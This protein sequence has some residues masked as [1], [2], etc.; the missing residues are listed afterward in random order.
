MDSTKNMEPNVHE[1]SKTSLVKSEHSH[2]K[3]LYTMDSIPQEPR[4]EGETWCTARGKKIVCIVSIA[5]GLIGAAII[6][7]VLC[8]NYASMPVTRSDCEK[9]CGTNGTCVLSAQW[10]DGVSDCPN[11]EDETSCVQTRACQMLCGSSGVC[12]LYS[13]WCD[14]IPQ[15]PNGTDEQT[16]VRLYGPNFQLQAYSPAK[17][18][19]LPVCYDEWSDNSGK[20]ACQ[21]IGYSMSSYYQSSQLLASSSNGYFVLQSSNVTGKMYTN[22]NYSATCASG[23]MVSL[24]CISCGLST[25]VDSRIVGGT[26]AS[27]GDWPWQVE[28]LKLVGT[29]IYLC[30]GS[31][32]TPHWIVTAAHCVYGSTS[33]PS[34]FKVFAGSLTIQSYYSAGYTVERAL[35]H[36]SYSSYTQIY[37]VA[38]LKLTA[39]LVFTTNLRPV[40]LPNVGMPWAEGQPCWISG[41]G[42]TA[43][44]G[45]ISKNLMAASVPIIS[46]TTC[47]QAAVYGGAISSTMMCAGYLSGG[48]DTCQGDSGGP[49]VTKTNSL[50][51]LVGDTSWGY[52]C[53]RAYK[54]G[55]YGN[56]TVFIEWIY[57]QMQTYGG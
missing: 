23:N 12:V 44:G 22:L 31:I 27:V 37:D 40:C 35:V 34:A 29:S 13:Q 18:T 45:S 4:K 6:I 1:S 30:G 33:T 46:S 49:L 3:K 48:T 55:V 9:E 14:G 19:W 56:V 41:W 50:W 10:C 51:W 25:K 38:L 15:C 53:A 32:I 26:P 17:A 42:T 2:A 54:P 5:F 36:P 57:S 11:G 16:C 39:A 43:E 21:D 28:L 24:R 8:S 47:N 20:I 52:G 7:A